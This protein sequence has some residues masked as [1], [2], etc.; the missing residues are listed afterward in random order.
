MAD[1]QGLLK[2]YKGISGERFFA[3]VFE[4]DEYAP[5]RDVKAD[6][7]I[8][9]GACAGEFSAYIYDKARVIF[10]LEPYREHYNELCDNVDEFGMDK[11]IPINLA[12]S[13]YNGDGSLVITGRGGHKLIKGHGSDKTE[14]VKVL[15]LAQFM[16]DHGIDHVDVLKI[17]VENGEGAIFNSQDFKEVAPHIDFIIGEHIAD[18]QDLFE[19]LGYKTRSFPN[20]KNVVFQRNYA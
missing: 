5:A 15:T 7:V 14:T 3:E 8:D 2:K 12:L 4:N 20:N 10:A 9:V 11:V 13:D 1:I 19:N 18:L 17:D 16:K 6:V